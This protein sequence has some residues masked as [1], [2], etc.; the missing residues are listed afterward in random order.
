MPI[1]SPDGQVF[2]DNNTGDIFFS[3][4][5]GQYGRSEPYSGNS[6]EA[7]ILPIMKQLKRPIQ[8]RKPKGTIQ[9]FNTTSGVGTVSP[10]VTVS[11]PGTVSAAR[12]VSAPGTVSAPTVSPT[13]SAPTVS[14]TTVSTRKHIGA[15]PP[16]SMTRRATT[17]LRKQLNAGIA[18]HLA[19]KNAVNASVATVKSNMPTRLP[20]QV[21]NKISRANRLNLNQSVFSKAPYTLRNK[22]RNAKGRFENAARQPGAEVG[23]KLAPSTLPPITLNNA[24]NNSLPPFTLKPLENR[25]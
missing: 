16:S 13:V 2:V 10:P 17:T 14:A 11:A 1:F 21:G 12:T 22:L 18:A 6:L 5:K 15:P 9:H 23:L 3:L 25:K 7:A 8:G 19:G 24:N 20:E 4:K